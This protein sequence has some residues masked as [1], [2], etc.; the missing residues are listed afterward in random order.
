MATDHARKLNDTS[1]TWTQTVDTENDL[2]AATGVTLYVR[3]P[4]G[5][6][7]VTGVAVT[8]DDA[9]TFSHTFAAGDFAQTG[10]HKAELH[11]DVDG[12]GENQILPVDG[13]FNIRIYDELST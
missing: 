12:A 9:S 7:T 2:T 13:Y 8:V 6:L 11:V 5:A 4:E 3:D 1:T 10:G